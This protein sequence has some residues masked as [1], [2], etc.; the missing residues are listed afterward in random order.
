[1]IIICMPFVMSKKMLLLI[2][3]G[4]L[5]NVPKLVVKPPSIELYACF[6]N[7]SASTD[8]KFSLNSTYSIL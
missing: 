2:Y 6:A 1:V 8:G 4:P 5:K 3:L 7:R